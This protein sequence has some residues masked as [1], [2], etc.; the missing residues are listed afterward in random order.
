MR[1]TFLSIFVAVAA[2][3]CGG[4]ALA[5]TAQVSGQVTDPQRLAVANADVSSTYSAELSTRNSC[6]ASTD[7]RPF[8]W[9]TIWSLLEEA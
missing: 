8:A 7:I 2:L 3:V 6:K 1:R 4:S 5:Q 9:R